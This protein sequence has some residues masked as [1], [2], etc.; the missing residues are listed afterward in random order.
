[1]TDGLGLTQVVR[2]VTRPVAD[3]GTLLDQVYV[4]SSD[5]VLDCSVLP[6]LH[7]SDHLCVLVCLSVQKPRSRGPRRRVWLYGKAD[8]ESMNHALENDLA[9]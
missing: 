9:D 2:S 4:S 5:L 3:A 1:M 6:S 8:F 7:S